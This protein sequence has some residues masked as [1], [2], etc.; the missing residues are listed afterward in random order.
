[1]T[2]VA[3]AKPGRALIA[4]LVFAISSGFSHNVH[5]LQPGAEQLA[6]Q[7]LKRSGI[8]G[9]FVVH[10]GCGDGS[11]TAALRADERYLVHGI[12]LRSENVEAARS[13]IRS[14]GLY[15]K[16]SVD[17]LQGSRLPYID[18]F[19]NLIIAENTGDIPPHELLRVLA[20]RGVALTR[21]NDGSWAKT[22]KPRPPNIDD[23]THYLHDASGNA[24][25]H[26]T[27]VAPPRHM[28][29]LG[30]PRWSRHHD[31]MASM[32]ALVSAGGRIF[33]IMDEGSR[34]SIQMP[35]EWY[36]IARDAYNG[37]V[38]WKRPIRRWHSHLW[39]LKSGP[40]QLARR[41]VATE[42]TVFVTPGIRAPLVAIDAATGRTIRTYE[43][44]TA[45]EEVV[46]HKGYLVALVNKGESELARY[47]PAQNV[48]DQRRVSRE[49]HWNEKPRHLMG[50]DAVTGE[51][52][53]QRETVC[54]P[55]TLSASGD[56][57][58]YH[59]G[60]KIVCVGLA[61]GN[62]AWSSQPVQRRRE[63]PFHFGPKLVIERGV[64]L[65]AGGDR[66]MTAWDAATGTKLWTKPHARGGYR[67]PED[68]LVVDG[69]VWSAPTS[70]G[71][72]S[73]TWTGRDLQTGEV[74]I[75]FPPNVE[76]YWFHHRCYIAKA[77][78]RFLLPSRTGIEFVDY[79]NKDWNIN[80]WVRGGC[81]YGVMPCNGM[82][83]APPHNC[84][85]YPEAKLYG[86]N[87]LAPPRS[88]PESRSDDERLERGP[89]RDGGRSFGGTALEQEWPTYR[90]DSARSGST[91]SAVPAELKTAWEIE[92]GGRV[93]APTVAGGRLFVAEVDGHTVHAVDA[94]SGEKL[95]SYT[96]GGRVD[97]PP[98]VV[99]HWL[100]FGSRDG[101][102]YCLRAETGGLKWRF[103]AAPLDRRLMAF[104]QLES[105]WPVPGSV[106]VED[107]VVTFVAG[108]SSFLDGGL[109][110]YR[111]NAE[112]GDML[113]ETII[114]DKDP[115]TG[116]NLQTRINVLNMPVGLNDILSSDGNHVY[117]RSQQFDQQ[118]QRVAI[119]P[120]SGD[121]AVQGS[122]QKGDTR[123]LFAPL[124]FLD[125]TYF[126]RAYWVYGRSFAGGHSGYHQAGKYT[127]SGRL[128]VHDEEEVYG[129]A[130]KPQ[131]YRWTTTIEH[132]MF[133]SPI[134]APPEARSA[135][136][137]R[138][139]RR[140]MSGSSVDV[141]RSPSL[142][143]TGKPLAVEAW[144]KA[145]KPNGVVLAHG[146]PANGYAIVVRGGQP[147]FVVRSNHAVASAIAKDNIVGKWVHLVGVLGKDQQIGIYVNG[148]MVGRGTAPGFV[149]SP[150]VQGMQIGADGGSAVGSYKSP[151]HFSGIIDEVR[152]YHG[153]L[154][155]D[156]IQRRFSGAKSVPDNAR[157][158]LS[159]AF[160]GGEARDSSANRNHGTVARVRQAK[161]QVGGGLRFAGGAPRADSF[162]VPY[163]W[164]LDVPLFVRA[165]VLAGELL[166][167]AGPP[168]V[169][170]EEE[171]FR[172]LMT[173]DPESQQKIAAQSD[174]LDGAQGGILLVLSVA[175]GKIM[176]RH[177]IPSL[178]E[179][180][181][182]AAAYG[183]LFLST[184]KGTVICL[185][186]K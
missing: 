52:L 155:P 140:G 61:S 18:N 60:G 153:V 68:V 11:L 181:G 148:K 141:E 129:F 6:K 66:M 84:A 151:F 86:F 109:R 146:G 99:G 163:R 131:Y 111:L 147:R 26:D 117:L 72:D 112:S 74:K 144:V 184:K 120:H 38:L 113:S 143:P 126:H 77:T 130:R 5:A 121:P 96:A 101:Y 179:W 50:F 67:S 87:A 135:E 24:V 40:T 183:K 156:D 185:D 43:E 22:V 133:A 54:V 35:A 169:M 7:L 83:Y 36:L 30:N 119:G 172:G 10:L 134:T 37:T 186:G 125:D 42:D 123:H 90:H 154:A 132:Q 128:L 127:P 93:S 166:F 51:R 81:L 157:V 21:R 1:M 32:S 91:P 138:R 31:R 46:Y 118:G 110:L 170:D 44:S 177:R 160:D 34:I 23:W 95:W 124:G 152:V 89:E 63:M 12:D 17:R 13:N 78:D 15:G 145:E 82:I 33:Y 71:R 167:V 80:H 176:A 165:L 103:R 79:E 4:S 97:S 161:G 25:A 168:D 139:V 41:L 19:V 88:V 65:F 100:F 136:T 69:V 115:A 28:Q 162:F 105:V 107:G 175:D 53:W 20:P 104:E 29:W 2:I 142:D 173:R 149:A 75:E 137:A 8:R 178:P 159:Y 76:T 62:V 45:T 116:E 27:V 102:V 164:T 174:A 150:P 70:S 3:A 64:V 16:V 49:F 182:M 48:G 59:D 39:P 47:A 108:R 114:N 98:T 9:G 171:T 85:C 14:V 180:D 57:A 73:G 122:I 56:R 106:L 158:V 58:F 94:S 55:L 92:F